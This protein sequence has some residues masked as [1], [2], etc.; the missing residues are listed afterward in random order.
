MI[1]SSTADFFN[2]EDVSLATGAGTLT[3]KSFLPDLKI[4]HSQKNSS[5]YSQNSRN[6]ESKSNFRNKSN[7]TV[8]RDK[9]IGLIMV[10]I[11]I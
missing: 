7:Q 8:F 3:R 6:W 5:N 10:T 2:L 9:I 1:I 11:L 4:D